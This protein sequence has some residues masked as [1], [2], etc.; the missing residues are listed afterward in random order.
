MTKR[1]IKGWLKSEISEM[2]TVPEVTHSDGAYRS[3][4]LGTATELD[5]CGRYHHVLSPNGYTSRCGRFWENLEN[6]AQELGGWIEAGEGDPLDTFFCLPR[7]DDNLPL[8]TQ[9][10][11][12]VKEH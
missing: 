8:I 2:V 12:L 11:A 4:Y 1:E 6:V 9:A 7:E 3:V 10:I 5:P